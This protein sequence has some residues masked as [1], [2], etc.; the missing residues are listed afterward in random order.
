MIDIFFE[1]TI[2][3]KQL[4]FSSIYWFN[5]L[6]QDEYSILLGHTWS[7]AVEE[8]FYLIWPPVFIFL[9]KTKISPTTQ[10]FILLLLIYSLQMLQ[11]SLYSDDRLARTYRLSGWT[12]SAAIYLFAGCVGGIMLHTSWWEKVSSI[13]STSIGLG[14]IFL[15]GYLIDFWYN[16]VDNFQK[17][18]RIVGILSGI[19]WVVINQ[20]SI[21]TKILEFK[22]IAYLGKVSYGIYV[23]QGFYL[24]TGPGRVSGQ[25]WPLAADIKLQSLTSTG[26]IL[27]C[28]TV[29]ISYHFFEV[30]F[31]RLKE[32]YRPKKII[33][34][35]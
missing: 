30:K 7:L 35:S 6:P 11:D 8:H 33:I 19:L 15:F 2:T 25:E 5:H 4:F 32:K 34:E 16:E 26:F 10:I 24:A 12:S 13:R 1:T 29:P 14:I 3:T 31:L 20:E 21:L 28:F 27:L 17:Y 18:A 23:W 9:L 22:P